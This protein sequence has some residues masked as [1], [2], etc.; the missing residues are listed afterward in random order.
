VFRIL[1]A[2]VLLSVTAPAFAG[3]EE[4]HS[5]VID[6]HAPPTALS[7]CLKAHAHDAPSA[8][9]QLYVASKAKLYECMDEGGCAA[10][11]VGDAVDGVIYNAPRR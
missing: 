2:A 5:L 6:P 9:S 4:C 8:R 10:R 1:L 11:E 7:D 3:L